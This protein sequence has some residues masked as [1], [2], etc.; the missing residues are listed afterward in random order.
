MTH[1]LLD[2]WV[3]Y[4]VHWGDIG[5]V[6]PAPGT[7]RNRGRGDPLEMLGGHKGR[8]RGWSQNRYR[9]NHVDIRVCCPHRR[10][11][12]ESRTGCSTWSPLLCCTAFPAVLANTDVCVKFGFDTTDHVFKTAMICE[13]EHWV[14]QAVGCSVCV[15]SCLSH[16]WLCNDTDCN[17]PESSVPGI[18]QARILE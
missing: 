15:L 13:K 6:F 5:Y 18:L 14:E 1:L 4:P 8:R 2:S 9:V 11:L 17:P 12:Q 16:V 10:E 3:V 7:T